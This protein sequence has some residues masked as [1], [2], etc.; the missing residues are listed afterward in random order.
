MAN[1]PLSALGPV[2]GPN[3]IIVEVND[4]TGKL[5]KLNIYPDVNNPLLK[6]NGLAT[7]YYI[8]PKE[9]YLARKED[10]PSDYDFAMT[11]F[12]GLMTTEDTIGITDANTSSG[13]ATSGGGFCTF[14]TT[15][16]IP[17]NVIQKAI[18]KLKAKDYPTAQ[19]PVAFLSLFHIEQNDPEPNLGIVDILENNVT[20]EVPAL[21]GVGDS[22]LPYYI[23]AQ[24]SG[25]GSIEADSI[26]AF[27]LTCNQIAAGAIAGSIE[28]G[29]APFTVH[30]NLKQR[31][32]INA[33]DIHVD[34]DVDK[35]FEQFSGAL[36]AGGF[37]GIDNIS[38]SYNYQK[39]LT[40]GAITT[41]MTMDGANIP[42]DLKKMIEQRVDDMQKLAFDLVKHEIFDWTPTPDAPAT[43]DRGLLGSLFG[44]ASVSLKGN[45]QKHN[46]HLNQNFTLNTSIAVN[47]TAA[48]DLNDLE[49]AIKANKGKY[50]MIVDIGEYFKKLQVAATNNANWKEKLSDGTDLADPIQ[51]IQ[52]EVGYLDYD[53]PLNANNVPN[54]QYRAS[55]FHYTIGH[56][57]PN[58]GAELA[59][60]T[61]DNP[62]DIINISFLK[63]DKNI[64]NWDVNQVMIRKTIVFNADDPR[65]EL[66]NGGTTFVKEEISKDH[67]PT[68]TPS[69]VGYVFVKFMLDR[70]LPKDNITLTL[71][72]KLANRKDTITI[73]RQ[74]QKNVIWEIFS[75]KHLN[76]TSFQYQVQVEVT[77]PNFT[78]TPVQYAGDW[79]TVD[80]PTSR[81]KYVNP[82]K[83]VLPSPSASDV[84]TINNYIKNYQS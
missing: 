55:G 40:S 10:S 4:D 70:I 16:A 26:S 39:C 60:W 53:N 82:L 30:Y 14:K 76:E 44:G 66:A 31:F 75:D 72:C 63:L 25:K 84:A 51:S 80:L 15:F 8:Q 77:G 35:V 5:F 3:F 54:P 34:V 23:N 18:Q 56:N 32:Y 2:F 46:V 45:Y 64:P 9:V 59:I 83:V 61:P 43:A 69:E 41:I 11:V 47:D 62:G 7:H 19:L 50:L 73:T 58:Q 79:Q 57:D 74:N 17:E 49:S 52:V 37:L 81:V 6:E 68:I 20:V 24:G 21:Q 48:G 13:E 22:K 38:L 33:C 78:D 71:V 1:E 27:L 67:A 36:S 28:Q 29:H 42:D 12:K 65:V